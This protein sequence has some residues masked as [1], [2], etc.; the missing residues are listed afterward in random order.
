MYTA[1]PSEGERFYMRLLLTHV[2]GP[3]AFEDLRTVDG[4]ECAT[5]QEACLRHGFL[6][7]DSHLDAAMSEAGHT[8][9]AGQMRHLFAA[10]LAHSVPNDPER[11]WRNH[12]FDLCE[13]YLNAERRVRTSTPPPA[14]HAA[15]HLTAVKT[16]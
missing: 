6:Q 13:D 11:L 14:W 2:R 8:A 16:S 1:N 5:F 4:V 15:I 9:T 7:D 3:T 10:I 12:D